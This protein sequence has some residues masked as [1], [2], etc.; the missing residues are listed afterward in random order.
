[1]RRRG[2]RRVY[3][4]ILEGSMTAIEGRHV[5]SPCLVHTEAVPVHP[6]PLHIYGQMGSVCHTIHYYSGLATCR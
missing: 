5:R 2:R 6:P 4:K 1:M 3:L